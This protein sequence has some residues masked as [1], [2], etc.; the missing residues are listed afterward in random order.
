MNRRDCLKRLA[1]ASSG[2]SFP[3]L[4]SGCASRPGAS[5]TASDDALRR[6]AL[7]APLSG[8]LS[9]QGREMEQ[10]AR[11]AV[12][13]W[14]GAGLIVEDTGDSPGSASQAASRAL[15]QGAEAI[16]GPVLSGQA[17]GAW[18]V[19]QGRAAVFSLSNDPALLNTGIRLVGITPDE[20]AAAILRYAAGR[21]VRRVAVLGDG[22]AWSRHCAAAASAF[23]GPLGLETGPVAQAAAGEEAEA[24]MRVARAAPDAVLI[25]PGGE[26]LARLAA[27]A[28]AAGAQLLGTHQWTQAAADGTAPEGGWFCLADPGAGGAFADRFSARHQARPGHLAL[29]AHDAVLAALDGPEDDPIRGATGWLRFAPDGGARRGLAIAVSGRTGARLVQQA[30]LS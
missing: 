2:L 3:P 13:D 30:A 12:E 18:Q 5:G 17:A 4:L 8:R 26:A 28:G 19:A 29:L 7:L 6:V 16:A 9:A 14:P 10:A 23:A 1:A 27:H 22:G 21:G 11:L 24:A 20:S 25:P 15:D